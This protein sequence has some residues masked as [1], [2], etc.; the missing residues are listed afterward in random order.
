MVWCH[1]LLLSEAMLILA[2]QMLWHPHFQDN[3]S[4]AESTADSMIGHPHAYL[5]PVDELVSHE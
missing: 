3:L 4:R 2:I 5:N 1:K